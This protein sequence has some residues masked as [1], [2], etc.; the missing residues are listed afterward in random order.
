M[1][2]DATPPET[3]A[4]TVD[5]AVDPSDEELGLPHACMIVA[6]VRNPQALPA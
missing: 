1:F 6:A 3:V 5:S 2:A 4:L